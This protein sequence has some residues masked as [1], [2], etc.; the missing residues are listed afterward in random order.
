MTQVESLTGISAH[1][2]RIWERRY[3]FLKPKRTET[4]IRFYS[5]E[6]LK[7]LLNV[8]ILNRNGFRITKLI[9]CQI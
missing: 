8:G 1:K 3:S 9:K 6:Q 4:N 5:A 2:L 7:K